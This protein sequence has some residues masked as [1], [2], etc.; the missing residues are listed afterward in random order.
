MRF[1][2]P[3]A[4]QRNMPA[5]PFLAVIAAVLTLLTLL[6]VYTSQNLT[7]TRRRLEES[8]RQEGLTLIRAIDAGNRTGRRMHWTVNGLQALVEE[9]GGLPK[10]VYVSVI[11]AD[12]TILA[13]SDSRNIG[14]R[15]SMDALELPAGMTMRTDI[16]H[17]SQGDALAILVKMTPFRPGQNGQP[18][19]RGR[20]MH[21][22]EHADDFPETAFARLGMS[23][24]E[25]E[26]IR[27]SD[28][29]EAALMF[30]LLFVVG[31]AA[32]YAIVSAQNAATV[33]QTLR[34]MQTY[35]QHVVNSMANGLISLNADGEIVTVNRQARLMFGL[36]P[37]EDVA[38]KPFAEVLAVHGLDLPAALR[39]NDMLREREVIC[40]TA[41]G[42]TL[43]LSLSASAL[44][45]DAG[46]R[47]GAVLLFR[48]LSEVRAL[49]AQIERAERL[50]SIGRLAAGVAHEIRNPL[51]S[52][53]GFLQYFQRKLPLD[54]QDKTYLSVMIQEVD[55]LNAVVSNLLEFARPKEPTLEA[56][57]V[58]EILRHALTLL[59]Q[60]AAAKQARIHR[61]FPDELPPMRLDRDQ[62]TQALLNLL[63]NAIQAIDAEGE[64]RVSA[65]VSA[66]SGS[67]EITIGDTGAGIA[68]DDLP[69]IFDPFF[70]TKKQGNG[71]GLAIAHAIIERHRGEISV[72][73]EPGRGATFRVRLPRSPQNVEAVAVF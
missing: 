51:G 49:Q 28:L 44:T 41:A 64:I 34:A 61:D 20:G 71:L 16:M 68:P 38:G 13:H 65:S 40:A 62:I 72:E 55:R 27:R 66:D 70:S 45:G 53:K 12:G 42:K 24:A 35:T 39:Q 1:Q 10:V 23:M 6:T 17:D 63:L 36:S 56:C 29:N 25:V 21:M 50:A 19:G 73:S 15:V 48:D 33:K 59:A 58:T 57:D 4:T 14:E 46:E 22:M 52:L 67:M 18:Q 37:D 9:I 60:D 54:A 5:F 8:L 11:A 30:L 3:R 26:Q 7:R 2:Q 32:L 31:S 69:R 43:P 47:L